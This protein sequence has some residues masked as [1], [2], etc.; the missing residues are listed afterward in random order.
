MINPH[1]SY[2]YSC[3]SIFGINVNHDMVA[4]P[5]RI[6]LRPTLEYEKDSKPMLPPK[7]K[8]PKDA[9]FHK[10][11]AARAARGSWNLAGRVSRK[12]VMLPQWEVMT[13]QERHRRTV[14]GYRFR[15]N[16]Q[17]F[18]DTLTRQG[19]TANVPKPG[20]REWVEIEQA[21]G[22]GNE[23]NRGDVDERLKDTFA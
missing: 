15:H 8:G 11:L 5:G 23:N 4:V 12:G 22:S 9:N 2:A 1:K 7:P 14:N 17:T 10:F 18:V 16:L 21:C 3:R 19:N 20:Y 6:L 13:I